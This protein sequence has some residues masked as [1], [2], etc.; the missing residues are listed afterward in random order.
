MKNKIN[1]IYVSASE[2]KIKNVVFGFAAILF[3]IGCA[4]ASYPVLAK[5]TDVKVTRDEPSKGC[6]N[7][8]SIEGRSNKI[9]DTI[10]AVLQDLKEEAIKKG[11]NF[12]KVETMGA[13][14]SAI[15]GV[16]YFCK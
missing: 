12:V 16:A 13:Q 4:S 5:T 9:N 11:A 6:E 15:K 14:G 8:G 10:E 1:L 7:L 3:T 2:F